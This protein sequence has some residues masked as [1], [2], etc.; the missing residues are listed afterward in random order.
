MIPPGARRRY[1]ASIC[2]PQ[3]VPVR[4]VSTLALLLALPLALACESTSDGTDNGPVPDT[5][6]EVD[7]IPD[8]GQPGPDFTM[9]TFNAGL[10]TGYVDYAP[11][12]LP[13]LGPALSALATD[14][15]CLE[16][17][18]TD[19]DAQAVIDATKAVFPHSYREATTDEGAAAGPA[20][21]TTELDPLKACAVANCDG[22]PAENLATCVL[23]KCGTEFGAITEACQTC[24][25]SQLGNPLD[26]MV[27]VC[28]TESGGQYAYAG[29]NGVLLLSKHPLGTKEMIRFDSYLNVRVA[30]H[31]VVQDPQL[32]NVDVFCTH[33]TADL[34]DV[35]YGGKEASWGAEQGKQIDALLQWIEQKRTAVVTL[36]GGDLN[37]GPAGTAGGVVAEHGEN[38][39]KFAAATAAGWVDPYVQQAGDTCTWCGNNPLVGGGSSTIIDHV[40]VRSGAGFQTEAT[41]VLDGAVELPL[42]PPVTSRLSDHYG[43]QVTVTVPLI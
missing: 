24:L 35:A 18:W 34:S 42:T 8:T 43:I 9:V 1:T 12:R 23:G 16:E 39:A 28:T 36:L 13:L 17:V 7:V 29:R 4:L 38:Y 32:G 3:E 14:V 20:C 19:E 11:D 2:M 15:V 25:A 37:C 21:T 31:A 41:R 26:D 33:L 22:V 30:L 40:M 6:P 27:A 10:A 5:I